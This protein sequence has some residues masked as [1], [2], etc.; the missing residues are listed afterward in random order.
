[1]DRYPRVT[2][3]GWT[4]LGNGRRK[5]DDH[6]MGSRPATDATV[7]NASPSC[8]AGD[9]QSGCWPAALGFPILSAGAAFV[10]RFTCRLSLGGTAQIH[11]RHNSIAFVIDTTANLEG[12]DLR[13]TA[14]EDVKCGN[15]GAISAASAKPYEDQVIPPG[16]KHWTSTRSSPS[17]P[18]V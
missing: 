5:A 1:M 10:V 8:R 2:W 6:R 3:S 12:R 7:A 17:S 15:C 14:G 13:G 16:M 11:R 9:R 4:A 18:Q